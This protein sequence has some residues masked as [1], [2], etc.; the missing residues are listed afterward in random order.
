[1]DYPR[2]LGGVKCTWQGLTEWDKTA[3]QL[4]TLNGQNMLLADFNPLFFN[5][6][7]E[8]VVATGDIYNKASKKIALNRW[9]VP[10]EYF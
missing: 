8:I 3:G 10:I 1:M 9:Q 5:T 2:L 4:D 6:Y 7:G